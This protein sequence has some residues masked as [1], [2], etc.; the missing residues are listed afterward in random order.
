MDSRSEWTYRAKTAAPALRAG[1]A[2]PVSIL[3]AIDDNNTQLKANRGV[4]AVIELD[5][6]ALTCCWSN[7]K[8]KLRKACHV[9][10]LIVPAFFN[11]KAWRNCPRLF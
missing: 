5:D 3:S 9:G 10:G 2:A 7:R 1:R 8:S 11:I 6:E 4:V